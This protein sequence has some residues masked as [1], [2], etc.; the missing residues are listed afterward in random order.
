MIEER[1]QQ[2][3]TFLQYLAEALDVPENLRRDAK[4]KYDHIGKWVKEDIPKI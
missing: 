2:L 1:Q 3:G 4:S